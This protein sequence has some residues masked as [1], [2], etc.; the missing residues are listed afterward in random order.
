MYKVIDSSDVILHILDARDPLGTMCESVLEFV[1]KEKSHKQVVLVINKCDLVPN[2]VTVRTLHIQYTF[3]N[4]RGTCRLVIFSTSPPAIPLLHSTHRLTIRSAK[5]PLSSFFA[6]LR[7]CIR[8]RNKSL[9]ASLDIPTSGKAVLSTP[10]K[11]ARFAAWLQYLVKPK[12]GS[13]LR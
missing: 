11:A 10:S 6:N 13:T 2:W 1:K 3:I 8:T 12:S 5:V 7:S 9:L 4:N